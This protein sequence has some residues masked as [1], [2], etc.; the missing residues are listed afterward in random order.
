MDNYKWYKS[1]EIQPEDCDFERTKC[2]IQKDFVVYI[3]SH[4][5]PA[6]AARAFDEDFGGWYWEFG[7]D[8]PFP[9]DYADRITMWMPIELPE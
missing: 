6:V 4:Y 7:L 2:A 9:S 3:N 8:T 5:D 1:C